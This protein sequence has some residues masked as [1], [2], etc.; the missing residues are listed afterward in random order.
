MLNKINPSVILTTNI[1]FSNLQKGA[2]NMPKNTLHISNRI[3][4][5][6]VSGCNLKCIH[7]SDLIQECNTILPANDI[8]RFHKEM[9]SYNITNCVVTGGEPTLH[10]DFEKI[11]YELAKM[12]NVTITTNGTTM[13]NDLIIYILQNNPNVILQISMDGLTP[14]TFENVR[15]E[16]TFNKVMLLIEHINRHNLNRQV[17]LSMTI[18][19]QNIDETKS[20]IDFARKHH[21]LYIHFPALL[22][23]GLAKEKW[24]N[25]APEINEQIAIEEMLLNEM[26]DENYDTDISSNRIEQIITHTIS[27][28]NIDCLQNITIKVSP[29]GDILPCPASPS[30]KGLEL[31]NI[32]VPY[33]AS[34]LLTK[35]ENKLQSFYN[36]AQQ[37]ITQQCGNC[38]VYEYCNARFC[39]NCGILS[40]C[41]EKYVNYGCQIMKHHL[42]NSIKE[43]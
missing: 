22:P 8:I 30:N 12:S 41:A 38:N 7:C 24:N 17:A 9:L 2:N 5:E 33:A 43:L 10:K 16:N 25:I 14:K 34:N 23:V 4:Y 42:N 27:K 19:K 28:G 18:M 31:G 32:S 21:F 36:C 11:I 26:C 39:A 13:K 15:G 40:E 1:I 3:Y 29:N 6:I 37:N 20:L 35:I